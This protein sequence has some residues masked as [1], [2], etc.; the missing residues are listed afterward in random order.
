VG[1]WDSCGS[2]VADGSE[3]VGGGA[4]LILG[5]GVGVGVMSGWFGGC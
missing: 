4:G 5:V 1:L 2:M 3:G